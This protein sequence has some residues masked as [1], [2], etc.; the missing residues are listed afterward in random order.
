MNYTIRIKMM[1]K[2]LSKLLVLNKMA[3]LEIPTH[4]AI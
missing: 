3:N 2:W 4:N 1:A